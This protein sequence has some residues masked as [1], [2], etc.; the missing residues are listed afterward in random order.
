MLDNLKKIKI[1]IKYINLGGGL[2]IIYNNEKI[3][4]PEKYAKLLKDFIL[5]Y[6]KKLTLIIEPGRFIAGNSGILLTRIVYI[7]KTYT[8]TFLLVDS[9]FNDL[10]RPTLYDAF[11]K[12]I[13]VNKIDKTKKFKVDIVGPICESGDFFAKDRMIPK[14][15]QNDYLAIMSAGAYGFTMSSNYNSRLK[16]AEVL[17][18]NNK[19]YL[20]RKRDTLNDLIKS[21]ILI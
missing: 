5:S 16:S 10:I 11:H 3:I 20:I 14:V 4:Q 7:K 19:P 2:G 6:D 12:I 13:P 21:E 15:N 18:K 9:A 8:K 1:D 17:V